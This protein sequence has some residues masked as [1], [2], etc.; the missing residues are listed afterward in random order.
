LVVFL[1]K[2]PP[3]KDLSALQAAIKGPEVVRAE[4]KQLYAVYPQGI[5]HSKL[6]NALIERKLGSRATARNWNTLLKLGTLATV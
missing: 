2:A 4:G 6:T 5:A 3:A 1:K